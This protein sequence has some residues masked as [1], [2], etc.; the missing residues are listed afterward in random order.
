MMAL[1]EQLNAE[2]I[3]YRYPSY[4][5]EPPSKRALNP[6]PTAEWYVQRAKEMAELWA[7]GLSLRKIG[8]LHGISQTQVRHHIR[9]YRLQRL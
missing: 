2:N 9:K 4:E 3:A 6:R 5:W 7:E 8:A 1:I